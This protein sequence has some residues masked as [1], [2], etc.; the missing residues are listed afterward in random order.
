MGGEGPIPYGVMTSYAAEHGITGEDLWLFRT[1]L[2]V[3][4]T[5]WLKQV[6]ERQKSRERKEGEHG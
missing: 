3:L 4:D 6:A 2:N 1:F 5:E